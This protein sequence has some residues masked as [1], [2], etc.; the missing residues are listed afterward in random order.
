MTSM[1]LQWSVVDDGALEGARNMARDH[2]L[3]LSLGPGRAAVRF[4]RWRG[5]TLSLGRNEPARR[6]FEA[7]RLARRGVDVVRRPTG[8]RAVLHHRE[9]TYSVCLPER[10]LGGV[11]RAYR[12]VN[13]GLVAGLRELGL[14]VR[15][16][17]DDAPVLPPDAGPC[18]RAPAPGEVTALGRKL[19]GSAQARLD[20][21]LLQHGSLLLHDDQPLLAE[22]AGGATSVP[23]EAGGG[24][25]ALV[26][27]VDPV[28]A[29][30]ELKH[31]LI[32]GLAA[33]LGGD[34]PEDW[35]TA[36]GRDTLTSSVED[37]WVAH[38][39]DPAWT[40]RR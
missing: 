7:E 32:Q 9:I 14:P 40:W 3:A 23:G 29:L 15:L 19:I 12:A 27:L 36:A 8:G 17:G 31:A 11:R 2:A 39:R 35:T 28:P 10:A 13:R 6:H 34:W 37:R 26:E 18:F 21:T 1:D 25:V 30:A 16:T 33:E 24:A 20:G 22:L 38:Y 4:Y 5:P